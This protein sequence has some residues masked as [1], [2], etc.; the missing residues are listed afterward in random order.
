MKKINLAIVEGQTLFRTGLLLT[1]KEHPEVN[2][3][4]EADSNHELMT[5]LKK[6]KVDMLLL[7]LC[8]T[9]INPIEVVEKISVQFPKIRI[10]VL[11]T[12]IDQLLITELI[13]LGVKGFLSKNSRPKE[14]IL[15]LK[16]VVENDQYLDDG[17]TRLVLSEF[18]TA[19]LEPLNSTTKYN[20]KELKV[21]E[22]IC[23]EYNTAE[24]ANKLNLSVRTIEGYRKKL[25]KKS[26]SK[27]VAG[28]VV[29]AMK[30]SLIEL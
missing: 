30:N 28:L 13:R 4:G 24:I 17:I 14:L 27:N 20:R 6:S 10:M 16:G 23:K 2:I 12:P 19:K 9:S 5:L 22:Y 7:D 11:Y 25:L 26:G 15:S 3:V 18:N 8:T 1:L 29:Y 21:L